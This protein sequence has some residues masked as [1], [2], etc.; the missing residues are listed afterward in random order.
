[1]NDPID[2]IRHLSGVNNR[3]DWKEYTGLN[4]SRTGMETREL[5]KKHD[6]KP[7]SPEWFK[8]WFSLPYFTGE[9]KI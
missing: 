5:E 8:L 7:G 9:K 4:I 1:M 6:I 2:E 3:P